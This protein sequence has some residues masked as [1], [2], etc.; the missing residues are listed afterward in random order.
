MTPLNLDTIAA[1]STPPGESGLAVFRISGPQAAAIC[2]RLF[3]P[4]GSRFPLPSK[5]EGYSMA[6]GIW[7]GI[8]EV[9]LSCFR[10]PHS[11]TGED[12]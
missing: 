5:M 10:A 12:V 3:S 4:Y 1:F 9:I 6:P 7:A 8:D 11:Y 2:D